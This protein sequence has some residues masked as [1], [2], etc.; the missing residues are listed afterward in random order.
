MDKSQN[1]ERY[2]IKKLKMIMVYLLM[3]KM[4]NQSEKRIKRRKKSKRSRFK[5]KARKVHKARRVHRANQKMKS[6]KWKASK[7]KTQAIKNWH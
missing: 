5:K 4:R 6:N 2:Q 1:K 7:I 3:L